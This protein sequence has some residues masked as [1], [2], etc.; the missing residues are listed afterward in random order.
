MYICGR[1]GKRQAGGRAGG[2]MTQPRR[3]IPCSHRYADWMQY[4]AVPDRMYRMYRYVGV[5]IQPITNR[6]IMIPE[7]SNVCRYSTK[8]SKYPESVDSYWTSLWSQ[9]GSI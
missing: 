3:A 2:G 4:A 1:A 6:L 7:C 5:C 9:F 8:Y